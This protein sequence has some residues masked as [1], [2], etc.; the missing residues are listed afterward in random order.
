M[1]LGDT[2]QLKSG[3]PVMTIREITN[4]FANCDWFDQDGKP[5]SRPFLLA[6]LHE[7]GLDHAEVFDTLSNVD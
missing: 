5:H 3:G 7:V 2:V 4:Q 1:K 6:S